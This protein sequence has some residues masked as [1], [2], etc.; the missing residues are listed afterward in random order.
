MVDS[1][2]IIDKLIKRIHPDYDLN[3]QEENKWRYYHIGL[4]LM[5]LLGVCALESFD[6]ITTQDMYGTFSF[7][8][9][10][11]L[12]EISVFLCHFLNMEK[13]LKI[14]SFSVRSCK[15]DYSVWGCGY[16]FC[17][18]EILADLAVFGV[19]RPIHHL[20]SGRDIIEHA[21]IGKWFSE[22]DLAVG[23]SSRV[24]EHS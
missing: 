15:V 18:K 11:I 10:F 8:P 4:H 1:S 19:L 14:L 7:Y 9:N 24:S 2:D 12:L 6:Y 17:V 21:L 23:Q 16:V 5:S 20:K 22:M 3:A 13:V